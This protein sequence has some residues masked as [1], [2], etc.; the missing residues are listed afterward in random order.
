MAQAELAASK[1]TGPESYPRLAT[2]VCNHGGK[3]AV[4]IRELSF[5][6]GRRWVLRD[7]NLSVVPGE[8]VAILGANG[9]GK[10]TLLQ[11]AAGIL[12]CTGGEVHWHGEPVNGSAAQRRAIGFVGHESGLYL[13]LTGR[14]NLVFAARMQGLDHVSDRVTETLDRFALGPHADH[15]VAC[16]SRGMR[17]RL[18]IARGVI[19]RPSLLFLDEPFSGLDSESCVLLAAY[20]QDMRRRGCALLFSSHDFE[21]ARALADRSVVVEAGR[22][23]G[24]TDPNLTPSGDAE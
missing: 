17:Q 14:E 2:T 5:R 12:R 1:T 22:L 24:Q 6:R 3:S 23:C 7:V 10:T 18:A 20:C 9:A 4:D 19:H 15:R 11:C 21:G 16:L 8:I 13:A